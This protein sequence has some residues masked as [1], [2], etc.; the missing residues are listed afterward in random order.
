MLS[1]KLRRNAFS[2]RCTAALAHWEKKRVL[3][4]GKAKGLLMRTYFLGRG[5]ALLRSS[6]NQHTPTRANTV[7]IEGN[8]GKYPS[9]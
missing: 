4:E 7:A 8:A 9:A 6:N 5:S 2:R 1:A 3:L